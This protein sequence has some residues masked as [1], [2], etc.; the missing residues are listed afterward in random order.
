ML[1]LFPA[2][3]IEEVQVDA[4]EAAILAEEHGLTAYDA[5]YLWVARGLR[6]VLVTPDE[7]LAAA[8]K[9][10]SGR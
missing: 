4:H 5:A 10:E 1:R 6:A 7:R 2:M 3:G 9:E 8:A